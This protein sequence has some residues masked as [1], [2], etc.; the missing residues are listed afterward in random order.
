M[1]KF[2]FSLVLLII[3]P[4]IGFAQERSIQV[5]E[6]GE[7]SRSIILSKENQESTIQQL[8]AFYSDN[9]YFDVQIS[10][11]DE[12]PISVKTGQRYKL[13]SLVFELEKDSTFADNELTGEFY[14]V[15]LIENRLKTEYDKFINE[16]YHN[17]ELRVS[18]IKLD[19]LDRSVSVIVSREKGRITLLSNIIFKGNRISSQSY[20]SRLAQMED[21][22]VASKENL[23]RIR[24]NLIS[25]ELVEQVSD[26]VIYLENDNY[27]VLF[28]V[29]E[30]NLNQLDGLIG[31][32]PDETGKGQ[33]VGD[34]DISLWNVLREGNAFEL[35][36]QRLKPETSRLKLGISQDWIAN[37]PLSIGMDFSFYQNDTTYQ[38]RNIGLSGSYFL[39]SEFSIK[40]RIYSQSSIS[41]STS[42][43]SKEPEGKKQGGDLGFNYSKL[44]RREVPTS[45]FSL[46]VIYGVAN[47]DIEEDSALAFRQQRLETKVKGYIPLFEKSVL[48]TSINGFYVIGDQ[49]TESDLVRFAGANSLRGYSEEQFT[50]SELLWGDI[51]Y[52]FL[53]DQYSYLFLFT[54]AGVYKRPQLYSETDNSFIQKDF[55]YSGGFGLSFR[56]AIGRLKFTYALSS[57]ETFG[58]G[59]VH[60]GISTGL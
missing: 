22:L 41:G 25:S 21:S 20:L 37:I 53:T 46:D 56:T 48:A 4:G 31:F 14:S 33:I 15:E 11:T 18:E 12:E 16:G 59:K 39:N 57:T 9:G 51:E 13:S 7:I 36:Y 45:G 38:T 50:A 3:I 23:D 42:N 44:D 32:V 27:V 8:T 54:A 24:R 47:K 1:T 5:L 17:A 35:Q 49:F 55:L 10:S 43:F 34:L 30:Q 40:S 58:N 52:R 19:S 6:N 60:F 28:E 26:P 2:L 29:K